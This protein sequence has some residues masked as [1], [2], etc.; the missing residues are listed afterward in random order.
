RYTAR[1]PASSNTPAGSSHRGPFGMGPVAAV[2]SGAA[3]G[4]ARTAHRPSSG[5]VIIGHYGVAR[6]CRADDSA[7]RA[8]RGLPDGL[9]AVLRWGVPGVLGR[10]GIGAGAHGQGGDCVGGP[11]TGGHGAA[12]NGLGPN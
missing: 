1:T 3:A 8:E 9:R 5:T 12:R 10:Q 4:S 7:K 11:R 2:A 6:M